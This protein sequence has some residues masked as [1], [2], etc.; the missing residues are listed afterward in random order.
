[1]SSDYNFQQWKK[2]LQ[3]LE[4]TIFVDLDYQERKAHDKE[5][6]DAVLRISGIL[7]SYMCCY[8]D[9]LDCLQQNLQVQKTV[10]IQKII[11]T[12]ASRILELK[13][14]L[15]KLDGSYYEFLCGGLTKHKLTPF[16][17]ELKCLP[18]KYIRP[19]NIQR[20]IS[21]AFQKARYK[22]EEEN[23]EENFEETASE[24]K[25]DNWWDLPDDAKESTKTKGI[26]IT[27][28]YEVEEKISEET[29]TKRKLLSLIQAH[30]KT[31][32]ITQQNILRHQR[33]ILWEKELSG[34]LK[35]PA[36]LEIRE[37]GATIIQK[38]MR[39]YF[40]LKRIRIKHCK[41]EELLGMNVCRHINHNSYQEKE[42]QLYLERCKLI[43]KFTE[44]WKNDY[45]NKKNLFF[46]QRK[47]FIADDYRDFIRDW[48]KRW[49][50]EVQF[51]HAIPKESQG[52][53]VNIIKEELPTPSE[54]LELY[55]TYMEQK[56]AKKNKTA[57]ELKYEKIE[58]KRE[59]IL[60]IKEEIKKKKLE[61]E[62]LKKIMKNPNM[63]P[64]YNFP[65]SK[66]VIRLI[67]SIEDYKSH[68]SD[69]DKLNILEVKQGFINEI[70]I[71]N[72]YCEA[73][74]E[75]LLSIDEDM[76]REYQMLMA[77]LKEDY[78]RNNE[79]MPENIKESAQRVKKKRKPKIDLAVKGILVEHP[80]T[81]IEDFLGD[82]NFVGDKL[83][84]DLK[85]VHP[86]GG[87]IRS[88]W[89]ERC[90]EVI[91]G[92]RRILLVGPSGSG[93]TVLVHIMA[94]IND[95]TLYD[96]N[97]L[98]FQ[99]KS[100]DEIKS[101]VAALLLC[102]HATQPS[103]IY[104]RHINRLYLKKAP[105]GEETNSTELR[106][107]LVKRLTRKIH[108]TDKISL[109][110]SCVV[111]WL[112]KSKQMTKHFPTVVLMPPILYATTQ[113]ILRN[114]VSSNR[115]V[116]PSLDIQSVA[117]HL[118]GHSVGYL[119]RMLEAFITA[120]RS[121]KIAASGLSPDEIYDYFLQSDDEPED[122]EKY[123]K[124]YIEK[125]H[126]GNIEKK[127][128]EDQIE[129]KINVERWMEKMEKNKKKKVTE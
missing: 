50:D 111:P 121:I 107:L 3:N 81:K 85:L 116:P 63:H 106:K 51:F 18:S 55:K 54:W 86:F 43:D 91:H 34:T 78:K 29:L 19:A 75:V 100:K 88:V 72:I 108:Q 10:Y 53:L 37:R 66:K 112:T 60:I 31:R 5:L 21:E 12:I 64:G 24:P 32:Q 119:K 52:G 20:I 99:N 102:A 70:D 84:C 96:L 73:N 44:R 39:K 80:T 118:Q 40:E 122:Y 76:R 95:A 83:K 22:S 71:E 77:A 2:A 74:E 123:H 48:F 46:R 126:W 57:A 49:F 68:W 8:N 26:N 47:D 87:E 127:H 120:N 36:R 82:Y 9:A 4:R 129:F 110:G 113:L 56:K 65:A 16:D 30:E 103:I 124:W 45:I 13:E 14:Q 115:I 97:L 69:W 17:T 104:I 94:T 105:V 128:T 89:W 117:R 33:R 101:L 109:I 15:R 92:F 58:A 61:A 11:K 59:E 1:M 28:I 67:E 25:I 90:R 38:V 125:T 98:E 62:L 93:K 79:D 7:G 114:W 23:P 35:P 41:I 42:R 27:E 6:C